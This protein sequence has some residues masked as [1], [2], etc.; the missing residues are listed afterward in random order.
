MRTVFPVPSRVFQETQ[1]QKQGP[2]HWSFWTPWAHPQAQG[3]PPMPSRSAPSE[4]WVPE[5]AVSRPSPAGTEEALIQPAVSQVPPETDAAQEQEP[6]QNPLVPGLSSSSSADKAVAG[7]SSSGSSPIDLRAHQDH[8]RRVALNMNLQVEEVPE[9]E[10]P[11]VDIL[12]AD[13]PARVALPFIRMIQANADTIWQ[14][15]ASVMP[16]ARGV[17]WK[18]MVPSK[19]Y[20][21]LYV[22]PPPCSH[23]VQSVNERERHDQQAAAPKSKE[24]RCM[25]LL[26]RKVYSTGGLQLRVAN[27][28]A[29]LSRYNYNT[30]MVV[31]KF[32]KFIPQDSSPEFA[33]LLEEGKKVARTSLQASLDAADSAAWTLA[34]GLRP[35]T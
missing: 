25:D 1:T 11:V 2:H 16:T 17:E 21:Y 23:V 19:G 31:E 24:A 34:S 29:L 22:H 26:G 8:L 33:A 28:K 18:Y 27:Q 10:D 6:M 35:S 14:S 20:E 9:I 32:K 13:T 30:W 3:A 15:P 12:L 5:A 7:T 4:D